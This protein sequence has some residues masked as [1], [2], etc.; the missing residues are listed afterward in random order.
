MREYAPK[1]RATGGVATI[2]QKMLDV[3][4]RIAAA[5][6]VRAD[7]DLTI[8]TAGGQALRLKVKQ[9]RRAG[10]ATMGTHM[11]NLKEGDTIA[12]VA[13]ISADLQEEANGGETAEAAAAPAPEE[14]PAQPDA[15]D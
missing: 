5:R 8:I 15:G 14:V 6:M 4:G 7:D 3:T 2:A 11:M 1:G 12:S 13:R 10:R 9:V